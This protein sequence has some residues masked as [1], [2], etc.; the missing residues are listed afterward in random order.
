M[1]NKGSFY[2]SNFWVCDIFWGWLFPEASF[3][4]LFISPWCLKRGTTAV[5]IRPW[6]CLAQTGRTA[7]EKSKRPTPLLVRIHSQ[8]RFVCVQQAALSPSTSSSLHHICPFAC[9][10]AGTFQKW[11]LCN[12]SQFSKS[13]NFVCVAC[14][15]PSPI[16]K[17]RGC[18]TIM[19]TATGGIR[20]STHSSPPASPPHRH[21]AAKW[22][23][24]TL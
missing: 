1:L 18:S 10:A 2:G 22:K 8:P 12:P 3:P 24:D 20:E 15:S 7:W 17:N 5:S 19:I 16:F 23:M 21:D 14:F 13:I 6:M 4:Q 9:H 11:L